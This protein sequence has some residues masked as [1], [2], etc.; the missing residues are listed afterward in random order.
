MVTRYTT[1][2]DGAAVQDPS[3]AN[4][5]RAIERANAKKW[6]DDVVADS[7]AEVDAIMKRL[8]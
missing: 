6:M 5:E 4:S 2:G 3:R 7:N 1:K 8:K